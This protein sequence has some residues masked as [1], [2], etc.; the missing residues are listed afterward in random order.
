MERAAARLYVPP[1]AAAAILRDLERHKLA[2]KRLDAPVAEFV[3][4]PAWDESGQLM[5]TIARTYTRRLAAVAT[6]IH[7]KA[8]KAVLEFARAFELKKD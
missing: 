3:Y 4:D 1:D 5:T 7:R 2:R 8:P 6:L